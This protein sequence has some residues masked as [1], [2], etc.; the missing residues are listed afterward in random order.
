MSSIQP[1]ELLILISRKLPS[2]ILRYIYSF[3]HV[4]NTYIVSKLIE[5]K[6]TIEIEENIYSQKYNTNKTILLSY[7]SHIDFILSRIIFLLQSNK[8]SLEYKHN[9]YQM[10]KKDYKCKL[11]ELDQFY[12]IINSNH[13][14]LFK[15]GY[16]L[17]K[18]DNTIIYK[19][20]NSIIKNVNGKNVCEGNCLFFTTTDIKMVEKMCLNKYYN[21][22]FNFK[23]L[24]SPNHY[25]VK[26]YLSRH[27]YIMFTSKLIKYLSNLRHTND[28]RIILCWD[29]GYNIIL[30]SY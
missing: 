10:L 17:D 9:V 19:T 7:K 30:E 14:T 6:N 27:N 1:N 2:D 18:K 16:I 23:L 24:M 26:F 3:I 22:I 20:L 13:V 15:D 25:L 5:L 21:V 28:E 12:Q 8:M 11:D 4:T 29:F